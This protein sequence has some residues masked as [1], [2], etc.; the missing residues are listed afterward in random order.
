M[1]TQGAARVYALDCCFRCRTLS[2]PHNTL[3]L[4]FNLIKL[5][6]R[7]WSSATLEDARFLRWTVNSIWVGSKA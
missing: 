2:L 4:S 7:R 1:S 6:P 3:F 5:R